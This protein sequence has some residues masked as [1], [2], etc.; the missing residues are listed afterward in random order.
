[1]T[2]GFVCLAIG[3]LGLASGIFLIRNREVVGANFS[4]AAGA[5][6]VVG[7]LVPLLLGA[8][9]LLVTAGPGISIP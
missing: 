9:V 3:L 5:V 2:L 1:M 4:I 6:V 8:V 7:S